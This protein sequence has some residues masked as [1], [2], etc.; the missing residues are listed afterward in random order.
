MHHRTRAVRT[1][2]RRQ[3]PRP[4]RAA[5]RDPDLDTRRRRDARARDRG[6]R[7][8]RAMRPSVGRTWRS[9]RSAHRAGCRRRSARRSPRPPG[10]DRCHGHRS[11]PTRATPLPLRGSLRPLHPGTGSRG[12][13]PSPLRHRWSPIPRARPAADRCPRRATLPSTRRCR[14]SSFDRISAGPASIAGARTRAPSR[15]DRCHLARPRAHRRGPHP[16]RSPSER[17]GGIRG[18]RA[19]IGHEDV[20]RP[21]PA[22]RQRH[23]PD[24]DHRAWLGPSR[25]RSLRPLAGR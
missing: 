15:R 17:R 8:P 10:A 1:P 9:R 16:V 4:A 3:P 7:R 23:Q 22:V 14:G 19:G 20:E 12:R 6:P 21:L 24:A 25:A 2:D 5:G 13:A 18:R 11:A